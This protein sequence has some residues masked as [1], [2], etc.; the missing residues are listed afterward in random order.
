[1][2]STASGAWQ[3]ARTANALLL[4]ESRRAP[5]QTLIGAIRGY[6]ELSG[7]LATT[8]ADAICDRLVHNAHVLK[9]GRLSL[10]VRHALSGMRTEAASGYVVLADPWENSHIGL[11]GT[12]TTALWASGLL[13]SRPIGPLLFIR[14]ADW[15]RLQGQQVGTCAEPRSATSK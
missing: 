8:I 14:L 12:A 1:M 6:A 3:D 2:E 5:P 11:S 13:E 10:G 15:I 7:I 4:G 9:L